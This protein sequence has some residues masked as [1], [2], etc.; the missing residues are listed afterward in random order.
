MTGLERV[1]A[2]AI[3][4]EYQYIAALNTKPIPRKISA[5]VLAP[6]FVKAPTAPPTRTNRPPIAAIRVQVLIRL[7][8][9]VISRSLLPCRCLQ[10][11]K[12]GSLRRPKRF[13]QRVAR[14]AREAFPQRA[15]AGDA[16]RLPP[17][18][19]PATQG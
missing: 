2:I 4:S 13:A 9:G 11:L 19:Q 5:P 18:R 7:M 3:L 17:H 12:E 14:E 16:A 8:P 1:V 15:V 6:S 10:R